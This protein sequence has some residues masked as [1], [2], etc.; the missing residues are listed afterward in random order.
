[1]TR[2]VSSLSNACANRS[3]NVCSN[4]GPRVSVQRFLGK[5]VLLEDYNLSLA[6]DL[7]AGVGVWLSVPEYPKSV[8]PSDNSVRMAVELNGFGAEDVTVECLI[9]RVSWL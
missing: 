8:P 2:R 7:M 6:R 4:P 9:G 5:I 3:Q 1:V